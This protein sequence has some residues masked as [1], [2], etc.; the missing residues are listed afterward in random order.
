MYPAVDRS[1]ILSRMVS[2]PLSLSLTRAKENVS[3]FNNRLVKFIQKDLNNTK[4]TYIPRR[5]LQIELLQEL[6]QILC[7]RCLLS[8]PELSAT[9]ALLH[10]SLD[11]SSPVSA[12]LRVDH[13]E[14]SRCKSWSPLLH[15]PLYEFLHILKN[16][17]FWVFV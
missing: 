16:N 14:D 10:H 5:T 11:F 4:E 15:F 13:L 12:S 3:T 6:L 17:E 9:P 7:F 8:W 1:V 2:S